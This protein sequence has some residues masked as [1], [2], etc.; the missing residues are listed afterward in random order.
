M[1]LSKKLLDILVC[2]KC[3]GELKYDGKSLTCSKCRLRFKV[4][5]GDIPDMVLE[6]AEKF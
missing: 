4:L 5:E 3:R 2:T 1:A 6:H